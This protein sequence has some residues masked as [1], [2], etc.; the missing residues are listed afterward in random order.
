MN[1]YTTANHSPSLPTER[2]GN[3]HQVAAIRAG[4]AL[5][6][7][8]LHPGARRTR[9]AHQPAMPTHL[10]PTR[11]SSGDA[12]FKRRRLHR[13]GN[14][15]PLPAKKHG[16]S[17]S[18]PRTRPIPKKLAPNERKA[19]RRRKHVPRCRP[20][21]ATSTPKKTFGDCQVH[22]EFMIPDASNSGVYLMGEYEVQILLH[23]R[24]T[25]RQARPRRLRRRLPHPRP[26]HQRP[27]SLRAVEHLRHHPSAP[28]VFDASGKKTENARF[29]EVFFN[30]KK[31]HENV[32][33]K[34][35]TG[36]ELPAAKIRR[37][38]PAP[39]RPRHLRLPQ[40]CESNRWI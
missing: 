4:T 40:T 35:P 2:G 30:G 9:S 31:I 5:P 15:A 16:V 12:L 27:F 39:G 8:L 28:R 10:R 13:A 24:Q 18:R 7:V 14:S 25:R 33:P 22:V 1:L 32:E 26:A 6:R 23:L 20:T 37:P 21:A 36:G 38:P 29:I 19:R 3:P 34:G 17:P 11:A